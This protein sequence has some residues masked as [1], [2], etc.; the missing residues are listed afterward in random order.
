MLNCVILLL[1][2][3]NSLSCNASTSLS[4]GITEHLP[5]L[6]GYKQNLDDAD[7]TNY[8]DNNR[9]GKQTDIMYLLH[10]DIANTQAL[11]NASLKSVLSVEDEKCEE[12]PKHRNKKD[13]LE[14]SH[15]LSGERNGKD[16][17]I[18]GYES[19]EIADTYSMRNIGMVGKFIITNGYALYHTEPKAI[20][21]ML[22]RI[23]VN[24]S[25]ITD[26]LII[27]QKKM[28]PLCS[29]LLLRI[30]N[31]HRSK[32]TNIIIISYAVFSSLISNLVGQQINSSLVN[33]INQAMAKTSERKNASEGNKLIMLTKYG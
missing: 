15:F 30:M 1:F 20:S 17:H 6:V 33:T 28:C 31:K 11:I 32:H 5:G 23:Q 4:E 10:G 29:E 24:N 16:L 27:S 3:V 25:D 22:A 9:L 12:S 2:I 18:F 14:I 7:Y 13:H 8:N 21:E 19:S 26:A